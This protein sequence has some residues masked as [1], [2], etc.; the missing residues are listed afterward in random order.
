MQD[1]VRRTNLHVIGTLRSLSNL[2]VL[3]EKKGE[4]GEAEELYQLARAAAA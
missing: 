1:D 3:L 2:A 4:L